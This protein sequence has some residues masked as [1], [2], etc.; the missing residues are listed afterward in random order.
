MGLSR[1]PELGAGAEAESSGRSV[2]RLLA[3][4]FVAHSLTHSL[5]VG[6]PRS[7]MACCQACEV[8]CSRRS[9]RRCW[10]EAQG[11]FPPELGTGPT[12]A[13]RKE[14]PANTSRPGW[15]FQH[16]NGGLTI[17]IV[18][19]PGIGLRTNKTSD[20]LRRG[21]ACVLACLFAC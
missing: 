13:S 3:R 19:R 9:H 18:H 4:S 14:N 11:S 20:E 21:I 12:N 17:Y 6:K 16:P 1:G 5:G 8:A 2:G 10:G 15:L 7:S